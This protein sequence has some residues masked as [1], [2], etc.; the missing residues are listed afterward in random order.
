M[1]KINL[2]TEF[3]MVV[4]GIPA[5]KPWTLP[6]RPNVDHLSA[7]VQL[8]EEVEQGEALL[9][10]LNRLPLGAIAVDTEFRFASEPVDLDRGRCWQDPDCSL[11]ARA[12]AA[13]RRCHHPGEIPQRRLHR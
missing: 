1:T 5:D 11:R 10:Q 3:E 13:E 8:I 7:E 4:E 6:I 12:R 9:A 2:L